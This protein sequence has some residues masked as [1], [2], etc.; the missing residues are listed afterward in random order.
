SLPR[1]S[2]RQRLGGF[3]LT[4][5]SASGTAVLR[6]YRS[7]AHRSS[8][9]D[10]GGLG[11]GSPLERILSPGFLWLC[12]RPFGLRELDCPPC[13]LRALAYVRA[14]RTSISRVLPNRCRLDRG[15]GVEYPS[16]TRKAQ[17][18]SGLRNRLASGV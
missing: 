4:S 2:C 1:I 8:G 13:S 15:S 3:R 12:L 10:T 9:G 18:F 14:L 17:V 11:S 6:F 16:S 5:G 7:P